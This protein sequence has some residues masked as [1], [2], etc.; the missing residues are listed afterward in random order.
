MDHAFECI[1]GP[2]SGTGINQIIDYIHPEGMIS[3][4][5][6][7]EEPVPLNTRMVLEK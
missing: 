5:R 7:S 1:G 4:L 6:V 3:I 2:A